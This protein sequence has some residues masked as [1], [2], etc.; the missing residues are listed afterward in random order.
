MTLLHIERFK[1]LVR[2]TI[3]RCNSR[4]IADIKALKEV[5]I[6]AVKCGK[7]HIVAKV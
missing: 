1:I 6:V 5:I 3:Q 2:A 7:C 4:V